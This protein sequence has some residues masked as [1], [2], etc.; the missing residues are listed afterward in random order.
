MF[1]TGPRRRLLNICTVR[2][3]VSVAH[4]I[5][6]TETVTYYQTSTQRAL[7]ICLSS[8]ANLA[9]RDVCRRLSNVSLRPGIPQQLRCLGQTIIVEAVNQHRDQEK[10]LDKHIA[11]EYKRQF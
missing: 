11:G 8:S 6:A 4:Q 9:P 2:S 5:S 10:E 7:L 3:Q 1:L